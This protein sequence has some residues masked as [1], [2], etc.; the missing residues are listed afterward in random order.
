M[1]GKARA[2]METKKG[3]N[4]RTEKGRIHGHKSLLEGQK[5][6]AFVIYKCVWDGRMDG[7]TDGQTRPLIESI[8]SS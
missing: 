6:E 8:R 5:A 3:K 2:V 4:R 7:R 1:R